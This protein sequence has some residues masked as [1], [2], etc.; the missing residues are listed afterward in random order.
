MAQPIIIEQPVVGKRPH[1]PLPL[2]VNL[3]PP[4]EIEISL[5]PV[6]LSAI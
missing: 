4:A 3:P 5:H 6:P 2:A 1:A